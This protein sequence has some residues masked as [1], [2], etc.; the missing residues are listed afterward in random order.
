[1]KPLLPSMA[2]ALRLTRAG[3]PAGATRVLMAGASGPTTSKAHVAAGPTPEKTSVIGGTVL[4]K[5]YTGAAGTLAYRLYLPANHGEAMP[6][7]VMLHGCTQSPEDFALGT[8]MDAL[9][10]ELGFMVAYPRQTSSANA[11]KCWNWFRPGDQQRDRGEPSLIAGAT[12]QILADHRGDPGRVYVAGLSAGG[13]AAA[14]LADQYPDLFAAVGVHSG[15][16]CG[17]ANDLSSALTAMNSGGGARTARKDRCFVPTITFHG[18][19][20]R[21]VN[22]ANSV[23]IIAAAQAAS[24]MPL[25]MH[26]MTER[27][28]GGRTYTRAVGTNAAGIAML[29][30]WTIHGAGHAWSGGQSAGSYTDP[31]GPD[32]SRE[33]LRFFLSHRRVN[34]PPA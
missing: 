18:D 5:R 28:S 9:A 24:D 10:D 1:M 3:D 16:P 12:R 33:M 25:T 21:T 19:K 13:A 14:I 2:E 22:N 7:V 17:A 29:E 20:D 8:G 30:Q 11:Q 23:D 31:Q 4:E 15:L 26:S 6:L 27:Q 32:A 34:S